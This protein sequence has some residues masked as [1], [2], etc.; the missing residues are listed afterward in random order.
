MARREKTYSDKKELARIMISHLTLNKLQKVTFH[1]SKNQLQ[2][3]QFYTVKCTA[4]HYVN[5]I[6][7]YQR[8]EFPIKKCSS[9]VMDQKRWI[10]KQTPSIFCIQETHLKSKEIHRLRVEDEKKFISHWKTKLNKTKLTQ[11]YLHYTK[12]HYT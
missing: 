1:K 9:R 11:P 5:N 6:L 8:N 10:R 12:F 7:Q 3:K 2:K 4:V